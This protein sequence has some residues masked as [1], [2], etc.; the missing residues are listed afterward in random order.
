MNFHGYDSW[1]V[2]PGEE[3]ERSTVFPEVEQEQFFLSVLG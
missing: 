2:F 1:I 3:Q